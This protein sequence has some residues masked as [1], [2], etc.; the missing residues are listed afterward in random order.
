MPRW[1]CGILVGALLAASG[2]FTAGV[3]G[4]GFVPLDG[5]P[6]RCYSTRFRG[7]SFINGVPE[8]LPV[9]FEPFFSIGVGPLG[10]K[11]DAPLSFGGRFTS[12]SHGYKPGIYVQGEFGA[13]PN[14]LRPG[15]SV[16]LSAGAAWSDVDINKGDYWMPRW[17][18][19][20]SIGITYWHQRQE[21]LNTSELVRGEFIGIDATFTAGTNIIDFFNGIGES[22][23]EGHHD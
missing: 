21:N 22:F 16:A 19:S 4:G 6:C 8:P 23:S 2:C 14:V 17:F 13:P 10:K 7:G 1:G 12:R 15:N 9:I 11:S 20:M 3:Q 18:G 5:G